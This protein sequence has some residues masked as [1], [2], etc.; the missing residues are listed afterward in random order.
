MV[1]MDFDYPF[2]F[3]I[4]T[5]IYSLNLPLRS[6]FTL[7]FLGK[8]SVAPY[9]TTLVGEEVRGF[10]LCVGV[11]LLCGWGGEGIELMFK[12]QTLTAGVINIQSYTNGHPFF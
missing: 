8:T 7:S 9:S 12:S 1:V 10:F 5:C 6:A 3:V 2:A 11:F 4:T